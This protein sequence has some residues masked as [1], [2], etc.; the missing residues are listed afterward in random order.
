MKHNL[1]NNS[2]FSII[3]TV[4]VM[5]ILALFAAVAVSL[6]TTG[7]NIG[8]QE[9][10]GDAA[11]YI[12]EGGLEKAVYKFKTGTSCNS[13][14]ETDT[15]LGQ[16]TFTIA[17]PAA[18]LYTL[19]NTLS[20]GIAAG[21]TIIPVTSSAGFAPKGRIIIDSEIIDYYDISGNSLINA[22]RGIAGTTDA[23]HLINAQVAQDQCRIA[24]TGAITSNPLAT[25]IQRVV[26]RNLQNPGAMMVYAKLSGDNIPYYRRWDGTSW[27]PELQATPVGA[28]FTIRYL[29]LKFART[30][31]EAILGTLDSN[32]DIRV[33]IWNVNTNTWSATTLVGNTT[34]GASIYRGFDI[35]YET[36]GD[37]AIVVYNTNTAN[38]ASYR[39]WDGTS[40]SVA[41]T[42]FLATIGVPRWIEMAP[43]PLSDSNDIALIALGS[44]TDVYGRLWTGTTWSD[45]GVGN[46]SWDASASTAARKAID[47]A[48]E[49]QAGR[50]MF[51]W[52]D[53]V[54][55][56]QYYRI[57]NGNTLAWDVGTT[58]LTITAMG[59]VANWVRLVPDL[60]SNRLMYGVQ[61]A[62][63]DINT[64]L[65]NGAAWDT[66]VQH[67][68]HDAS[69]EDIT[70]RNFDIV[71]ETNPINTGKAWLLWGNGSTVSRKQWDS[72]TNSWGAT[73]TVGDDTALVQ[74][75]A[76]PRSGVI[77]AGIYEDSTSATDDIWEM[78][79]TGG[80]WTA[81][82]TVWGGATVANPVNERVF[83]AVERYIPN[84]LRREVI[85]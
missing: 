39:I 28:G 47:V 53:S 24:S 59:G 9:E 57:W 36:S 58:Q 69:T 64:R 70:D 13:L 79:L 20:A 48:Y 25:P 68:E 50:V 4:M 60:T 7:S 26:E 30:R 27:G 37:R 84:I 38:Q 44:N 52:G 78:R 33:Q 6:V 51:I 16:G 83:I 85:Q 80:A 40:W 81:K 75:V 3:A 15:S 5:M 14:G 31:N 12:A 46:I 42:I 49:Q 43:N 8:L 67:P 11:F 17:G 29:V 72:G 35:E 77:F 74:L 55:I 82:F 19:S 65:W 21:A 66:A 2:G 18:T 34:A 22:V 45:M 1:L 56:D 76:H 61:D 32:G 23:A 54:A 10:Q 63:A 41:S 62:G 73:T 71:F